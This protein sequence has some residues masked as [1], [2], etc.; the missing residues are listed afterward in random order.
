LTDRLTQTR[1]I[2]TGAFFLALA[3]ALPVVFHM[4]GLGR[5]FL[6]MLLPV[7]LAGFVLPWRTA[8]L[9]GFLA[10]LLSML[11]TGMPPL[12][13]PIAP[14]MMVEL[15]IL[16]AIPALVYRSW[17]MGL[18]PALIAGIVV[19]RFVNFGM[20]VCMAEFFH[21]P[22]ITW[23]VI[24]LVTGIPGLVLQLVTIPVVI[25]LLE[26]RYPELNPHFKQN[27]TSE[28]NS[29]IEEII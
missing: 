21:I 24:N 25:P 17:R 8:A 14:M 9:T 26:K 23:G 6:P 2:A 28:S 4:V 29:L 15:T 5:V 3:L 27:T 11:L 20:H 16:G 13:P 10:P 18:W 19:S 12:A 22:G 1:H 7:L